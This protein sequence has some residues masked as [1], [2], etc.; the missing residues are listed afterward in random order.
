MTRLAVLAL[1][2]VGCDQPSAPIITTIPHPTAPVLSF[3]PRIPPR[4]NTER[5]CELALRTKEFVQFARLFA[6]C[7]DSK[8]MSRIEPLLIGPLRIRLPWS[9][10]VRLFAV[11][12][13]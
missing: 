8:D 1:V 13:N 3:E 12:G 2:V 7:W 10:R 11:V 5:V 6:R 9:D 4:H